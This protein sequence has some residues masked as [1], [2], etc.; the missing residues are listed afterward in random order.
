MGFGSSIYRYLDSIVFRNN[1]DVVP[2][3]P[4]VLP[5][6]TALHTVFRPLKCLRIAVPPPS[7]HSNT[8]STLQIS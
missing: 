8:V 6:R 3:S 5:S 4:H 1:S 2:P 7:H